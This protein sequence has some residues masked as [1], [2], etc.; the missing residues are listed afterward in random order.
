MKEDILLEKRK[1]RAEEK[2]RKK[3]VMGLREF[4][5]GKGGNG[6][7]IAVGIR[8]TKRSREEAHLVQVNKLMP[9]KILID[10]E[11]A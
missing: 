6:Q 3:N 5:Q 10:R 11:D 2:K 4:H 1:S 9:Q 7:S 8:P